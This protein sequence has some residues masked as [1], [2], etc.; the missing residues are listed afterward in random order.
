[1]RFHVPQPVGG[2]AQ[3]RIAK[4][5]SAGDPTAAGIHENIDNPIYCKLYQENVL[6][7]TKSI[8]ISHF[9]QRKRFRRYNV[10]ESI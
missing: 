6:N 9:V 3:A 8:K 5:L 2:G 1:M 7:C 10:L 4:H